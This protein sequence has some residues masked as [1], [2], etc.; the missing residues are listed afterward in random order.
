MIHDRVCESQ[1]LNKVSFEAGEL[2]FRLITRVDDNGNYY[3]DALRVYANCVSEK[4]G[5]TQQSTEKA[6]KDLTKVGLI[7][8]YEAD[9]RQYLHLTDFDKHQS[10]RKD[11]AADVAYPVHPSELGPAFTE[12]GERRD[13][14]VRERTE[15][16]RA[17]PMR[18][19]E[20]TKRPLEVEVKGE[21]EGEV[22]SHVH[23]DGRFSNFQTCFR[24]ALG[25]ATKPKP[26]DTAVQK[27]TELCRKFSETE[28]LDAINAY[29]SLHGKGSLYKN[30]FADRNFLFDEA[31]DLILAKKNGTLNPPTDESEDPAGRI[32]GACGIPEELMR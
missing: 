22:G 3:R 19:E 6:L 23:H 20:E 30:K 18:Y 4:E 26:F 13:K 29:V 2:W 15:P 27:Y 12:N 9:G 16:E 7:S 21:G 11:L 10:L 24:D 25:R 31:E 28:V 14:C 1:K 5:S 8:V 17:V 32:G